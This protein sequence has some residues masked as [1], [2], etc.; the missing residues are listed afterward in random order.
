MLVD[1]NL[2]RYVKMAGYLGA[3][4]GFPSYIRPSPILLFPSSLPAFAS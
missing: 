2:E 4:P 3:G 1:S